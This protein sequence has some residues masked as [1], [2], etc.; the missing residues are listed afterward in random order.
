MSNF[1]F[2]ASSFVALNRNLSMRAE[3]C[4]FMHKHSSITNGIKSKA[5]ESRNHIQVTRPN[6]PPS[7]PSTR[8]Q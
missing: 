4:A 6:D 5:N 8:L 2:V 1:V 7:G 3:I